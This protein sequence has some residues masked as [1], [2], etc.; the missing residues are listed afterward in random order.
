METAGAM[1]RFTSGVEH[2]GTLGNQ[3]EMVRSGECLGNLLMTRL[4]FGRSY[5]S[6]ARHLG[7]HHH[8]TIHR[9]AGHDNNGKHRHDTG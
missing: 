5:V 8:R 3:A 7:Q 4:T 6:R 2:V 9:G 1:T